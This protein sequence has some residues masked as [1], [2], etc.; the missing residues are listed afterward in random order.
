MRII[1]LVRRDLALVVFYDCLCHLKSDAV[2]ARELSCFIGAI[3]AV[4]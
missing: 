4:K 2:T 3:E 1:L